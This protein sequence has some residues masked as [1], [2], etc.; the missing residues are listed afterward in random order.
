MREPGIVYPPGPRTPALVQTATYVRDPVTA[1][2]RWADRYGDLFTIRIAGFGKFVFAAAPRAVVDTPGQV[3]TAGRSSRR[4]SI[5]SLACV[6]RFLCG[7][8]NARGNQRLCE[9]VR[10][11]TPRV[12]A[13][14]PPHEHRATR[15]PP[16][17]HRATRRPSR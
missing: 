5:N 3:R 6:D 11:G 15:R 8:V 13:A 10:G 12:A 2:E 7:A 4:H 1:L 17:E 9:R 16:H 14:R